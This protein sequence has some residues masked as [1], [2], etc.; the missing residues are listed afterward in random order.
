M[1]LTPE[2]LTIV[3]LNL[4]FIVFG[5]I[6]FI[7]SLKI[8]L[9]WN[10]DATSQKQYKLEKESF[11]ATT[12]I[13]FIFGL[14]VALFL[15]FIFILD[16]ISNVI[17]GAMC[18]AGVVDATE[19][20]SFLIVLKVINIYLFALW[21]K[22]NAQDM[23]DKE[24]SY[25]KLK[26][27]LYLFLYLFLIIEIILE[28]LM[29]NAIEVDKIVSCCGSI[30]SSSSNFAI[31]SVFLLDKFLVVAFFYLNY[32]FIA[33]GYFLKKRYIFAF[34]NFVFIPVSLLALI[35]FFGTYIYEL[36]SHHC[37][38]C[39]LQ[40]EYYHIGYII[41]FLLFVGTF[42]GISISFF[43]NSAA[44]YKISFLFNTLLVV[45]LSFFVILYYLKN[46]VLL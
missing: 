8:F 45:L 26:S 18:A 23:R 15:F 31:A 19:F 43:K 6:A 34:S 13:K 44:E 32:L 38:F 17:T 33:L 12:I 1:L 30:Y 11:L 5:S 21:L 22:I 25:T 42:L 2:V 27:L 4:L 9:Y 35:L 41:Y 3:I 37:P 16:K 20:G 29:F 39:I 14:K 7:L 46:G 28:T 24:Q 40:K 36:P 10:R